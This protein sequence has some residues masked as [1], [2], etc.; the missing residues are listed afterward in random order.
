MS[1]WHR[2][3]A[4]KYRK[5]EG[6]K[7]TKGPASLLDYLPAEFT[8]DELRDLV[9]KE[10]V[11]TSAPNLIKAWKWRKNIEPIIDS[12]ICYIKG[13]KE[14]PEGVRQALLEVCPNAKNIDDF[15]YSFAHSTDSTYYYVI[16]GIIAYAE[17][18]SHIELLKHIG[19]ELHPKKVEKFIEKIMYVPLNQNG[20]GVIWLSMNVYPTIEEA[21]LEKG[22]IGYREIKVMIKQ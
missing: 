3:K 11:L 4:V 9:E 10:G 16:N 18:D 20:V 15:E 19:T 6:S 5:T 13:S 7:K 22:A 21:M 1:K 2:A 12:K 8:L 17:D 14:N